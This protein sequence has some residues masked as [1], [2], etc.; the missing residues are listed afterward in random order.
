M[1]E[2]PGPD[3]EFEKMVGTK[4]IVEKYQ[5]LLYKEKPPDSDSSDEPFQFNLPTS[6]EERIKERI[7]LDKRLIEQRKKLT[8]REL[9]S[10]HKK[11]YKGASSIFRTTNAQSKVLSKLE[12][13]S[14]DS[15]KSARQ[16]TQSSAKK[17]K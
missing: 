12:K 4:Q 2:D 16:E 13:S 6:K 8:S 5:K 7:E 3:L 15:D 14:V 10:T 17:L 1:F 9:I 11:R